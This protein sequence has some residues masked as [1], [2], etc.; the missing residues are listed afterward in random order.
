MPKFIALLRGIN[1][2]KAKRVAMAE[3]KQLFSDL[4][5]TNVTTILNSGNVVFSG[6]KPSESKLEAAFT[7]RFGFS[8]NMTLVPASELV[9]VVEENPVAEIPDPTRF[10][11]A[12][13]KS[14]A[15]REKLIPLSRE[16]WHP[17]ILALGERVA[18]MWCPEGV[19]DSPLSAAVSKALKD[20]VTVRNYATVLKIRAALQ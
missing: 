8:S 1:V 2:G 5:Y 19:L 14:V 13:I 3:L 18:W 17:G 4:G 9:A 6:V 20:G 15:H 16:V 11:I 12:F 7:E 10:L